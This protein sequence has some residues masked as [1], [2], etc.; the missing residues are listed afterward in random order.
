MNTVVICI[1][2]YIQRQKTTI[3]IIIMLLLL[4][5]LVAID[6]LL[7]NNKFIPIL[8][9]NYCLS[10]HINN[11]QLEYCYYIE[12]YVSSSNGNGNVGDSSNNVIVG[13]IGKNQGDHDDTVDRHA[14]SSVS[15]LSANDIEKILWLLSETFE[16]Q[17]IHINKSFFNHPI[18]T[19]SNSSSS[20][21]D[22][23][24]SNNNKNQTNSS[25]P[26][27][28][29]DSLI[30]EC[31][32]R[33]AF[34]TAWSSNCLSMFHA[35]GITCI[36]RIERSRRYRLKYLNPSSLPLSS[37][38]SSKFTKADVD[39]IS[40]FLYDRMTECIYTEPL[41]SFNTSTTSTSSSSSSSSHI[42]PLLENG[43]NELIKINQLQGLGFDQ[44]DLEFYYNI[45]INILK[46]NPTDVECFDLGKYCIVL[47]YH[48]KHI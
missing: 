19:E 18:N 33:L 32:P 20:I 1:S 29:G 7:E 27:G 4:H 38:S 12:F 47:Y 13:G 37:S 24:T 48:H 8:C 35:C 6:N 16:P 39:Y 28:N 15:S 9:K 46:R 5:R 31:G 40:S 36:S 3:V 21:N 11:I 42:I 26:I 30:I 25:E 34:S 22:D 43:I 10:H 45:F 23:S 44:V 17:L 14:L 2:E 41:Q